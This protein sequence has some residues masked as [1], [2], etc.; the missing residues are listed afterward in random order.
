MIWKSSCIPRIKFFAWLVL[1]DRLNTKTMLRRRHL[2][3]EDDTLY[4]LCS[5]GMEEDIDHLFFECPFTVQCW[6]Y[7]NFTWDIGL[8]LPER[9]ATATSAHN[10]DFITEAALIVAW[11]LWKLRNDKIFQRRDPTSVIW[12]ANFKNQCL[13]QSVR[14]KDDFISS[15]C[16][17][18]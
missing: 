1:V 5:T 9:L 15:F 11:E 18:A 3:I 6:N 17:L 8:P 14:F 16:F 10:L 7:I 2:N 12:L 4:V 13:L